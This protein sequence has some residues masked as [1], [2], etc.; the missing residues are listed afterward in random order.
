[1][2]ILS[3]LNPVAQ[4][5]GVINAQAINPRPT[6]LDRLKVGLFWSGTAMGDVALRRVEELLKE[7]SPS[8]ETNFYR[9]GL[10][11]PEEVL[12][13]VSSE[14]DIVIGATAD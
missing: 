3:V 2:E 4:Q 6:S 7:R 12:E 11:A 10:P 14:S 8:I 1:M 5:R 9:G 13:K